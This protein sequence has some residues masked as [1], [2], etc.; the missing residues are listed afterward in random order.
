MEWCLGRFS[1]GHSKLWSFSV[2]G[3]HVAAGSDGQVLFWDRRTG[4]QAAAF[5]DMHAED[6]TQVS[7][8]T[9][10][11]EHAYWEMPLGKLY[12]AET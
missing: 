3:N 9:C 6:V 1:A 8:S 12:L 5:T 2:A 7:N 4:Q 11:I 10:H